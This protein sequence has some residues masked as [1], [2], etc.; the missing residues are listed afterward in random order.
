VN[1]IAELQAAV[2]NWSTSNFGRASGP[3]WSALVVVEEIGEACRALVKRHQGIRGTHDEWTAELRKEMA[4]ALIALC[5]MAGRADVDLDAAVTAR[6][7]EVSQRNWRK[8][9]T[10]HGIGES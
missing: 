8:D 4:D 2:D 6:R 7:A 5:E 1:D 3:E 9:K 10:G